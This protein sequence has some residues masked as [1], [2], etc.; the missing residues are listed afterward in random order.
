M[1]TNNGLDK[2]V[3]KLKFNGYLGNDLVL[4]HGAGAV[5][6]SCALYMNDPS[7]SGKIYDKGNPE[8]CLILEAGSRTLSQ[9][10]QLI[11]ESLL[12][13]TE[14]LDADNNVLK[15]TEKVAG[16]A[17]NDRI[18]VC[19]TASEND[20]VLYPCFGRQTVKQGSLVPGRDS[21]SASNCSIYVNGIKLGQ[22]GGGTVTVDEVID[23]DGTNPVSGRAIYS[24]LH[25]TMSYDKMSGGWS[26]AQGQPWQIVGN[27]Y[28]LYFNQFRNQ[29]ADPNTA[30]WTE[31]K[32]ETD[33]TFP[34]DPGFYMVHNGIYVLWDSDWK[35]NGDGSDRDKSIASENTVWWPYWFA[36][37]LYQSATIHFFNHG[38]YDMIIKWPSA[39]SFHEV[40]ED[41]KTK[42][43]TVQESLIKNGWKYYDRQANMFMNVSG[44][45]PDENK[46]LVIAPQTAT[47]ISLLHTFDDHAMLVPEHKVHA[48]LW[49]VDYVYQLD[50]S[51]D[52]GRIPNQ[53]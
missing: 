27:S 33:P 23:K 4:G 21:G 28:K 14:I 15:L 8:L 31:N 38:A 45:T 18:F 41:K 3:Q 16:S 7:A 37:G 2:A 20:G 1:F 24:A 5:P 25:G 40:V 13:D 29:N 17:G 12:V 26:R 35:Y 52:Y 44:S 46:Q 36:P 30:D 6:A 9:V 43:V 39:T 32:W 51:R 49:K 34:I 53:K 10:S 50:D 42:E 48:I 47:C 19:T 22:G 11:K